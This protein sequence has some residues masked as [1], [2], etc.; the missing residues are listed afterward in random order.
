MPVAN[1]KTAAKWAVRYNETENN[2]IHW[3]GYGIDSIRTFLKD[4][5]DII[6]GDTI[7]ELKCTSNV[8]DKSENIIQTLLQGA[9][10]KNI[11]NIIIFNPLNG[12]YIKYE[13]KQR[14]REKINSILNNII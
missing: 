6:N 9:C 14:Y 11:N 5:C 4:T 13:Y 10:D 3:K 7:I 2:Q 1:L 8:L 12:E